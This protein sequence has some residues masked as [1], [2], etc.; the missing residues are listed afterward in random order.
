MPIQG[1]GHKNLCL[2]RTASTLT[3]RCRA[4]KV[5][6]VKLHD[7]RQ[8]MRCIPLPHGGSDAPEHRPC[9]L[10]GRVAQLVEQRTEN[11]RAEGSSPPPT[12]IEIKG[13]KPLAQADMAVMQNRPS[14]DGG[15]A[16]AVGTLVQAVGQAATMFVP[17]FRTDK[18]VRPALRGQ[19]VPAVLLCSKPVH[20]L[21]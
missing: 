7:T 9:G 20:K 1:Q 14:C 3:A 11:P 13:Q 12:T 8:Q 21:T 5:G 2:F 15:L 4:S 17:A 10:I 6:V 16:V 19:I 18:T